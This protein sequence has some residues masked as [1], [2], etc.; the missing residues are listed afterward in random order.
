MTVS[1]G[2]LKFAAGL[3]SLAVLLAGCAG[4]GPSGEASTLASSVASATPAQ[5]SEPAASPTATPEGT[6]IAVASATVEGA[7]ERAWQGAG[8]AEAKACTSHPAIAPGGNVWVSACFENRFWIFSP[9][10]EYLESWGTPGSGDG[11]FNFVYG[12]GSDAIAGVAFA[13]DGSFYVVEAGNLRVQ[14]FDKNRQFLTSWGEFGTENGQFAKPTG[15]ALDGEGQV[16]VVDAAR[17]DVQIFSPEGNYLR[18][19]AQGW[20]GGHAGS[21]GYMT[22]TTDGNVFLSNWGAV[23]EYASDGRKLATYDVTALTPDCAGVA[24]D[25]V[26]HIFVLGDST[27][28]LASDGGVIHVWPA[29]GEMLTLGPDAQFFYVTHYTWPYVR[30]YN[31][32]AG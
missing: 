8:P 19:I 16:Y 31:L 11:E 13:S 18:T 22:V 32:P 30:K 26:G 10:G 20:L 1:G 2:L 25:A 12:G 7:L 3:T 9:D 27:I 24:V 15:I 4:A 29:T 6:Q 21:F 17:S 5:E 14:R 28:E 23:H